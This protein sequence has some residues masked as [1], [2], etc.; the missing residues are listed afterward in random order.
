MRTRLGSLCSSRS[1]LVMS[2]LVAIVLASVS[3][4]AQPLAPVDGKKT[5][6]VPIPGAKLDPKLNTVW[7]PAFIK[8]WKELQELV[9]GEPIE[10]EGALELSRAI[11]DAP[12]PSAYTPASALYSVAGFYTPEFAK[13]I[14]TELAHR[15]NDPPRPGL[16]GVEGGDLIAYA[17]LRSHLSFAVPYRESTEPLL[18]GDENGEKVAVLSFGTQGG[19]RSAHVERLRDQARVLYAVRSQTNRYRIVEAALNLAGSESEREVIVAL[20]EP[21]GSLADTWAAVRERLKESADGSGSR[22]GPVDV[23]AV[24]NVAFSLEQRFRSLEG[25][26]LGG[27][28]ANGRITTAQQD[29]AFRMDRGGASFDAGASMGWKSLAAW[30]IFDRPFL[31][32]IRQRG[33]AMPFLIM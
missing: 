5:V 33:S 7:C 12:D 14:D 24:P 17:F 21:Q 8:A 16:R 25:S 32:A 28:L 19:T 2:S 26:V 15:F 20:V 4:P 30:Y 22:L 31:L 1:W 29:M 27:P 18:F 3:A 23:L 13:K 10:V 11:S 6:I 9:G